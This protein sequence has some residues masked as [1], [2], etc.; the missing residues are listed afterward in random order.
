MRHHER[1]HCYFHLPTFQGRMSSG[2]IL[3]TPHPGFLDAVYL[4]ACYFTSIEPAPLSGSLRKLEAYFLARA[5]TSLAESLALSDRLMDF[6][7]GSILVTAYLF[8]RGRFLEG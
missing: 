6:V 2:N 1:V 4:M 3:T 5:Q 7:R 8:L